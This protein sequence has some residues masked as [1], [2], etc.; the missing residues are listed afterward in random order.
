MKKEHRTESVSEKPNPNA[1]CVEFVEKGWTGKRMHQAIK[2]ILSC[3]V[4]YTDLNQ[5]NN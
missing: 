3:S 5:L 4:S 1:D 2:S